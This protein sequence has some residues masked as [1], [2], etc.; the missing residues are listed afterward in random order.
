VAS[1]ASIDSFG[2]WK[3]LH[4]A[5]KRFYS[6]ILA[7]ACEEG[8]GVSLHVTNDT[9]NKVNGFMKWRLVDAITENV[10]MK[11]EREDVIEPLTA[12]EF[13]KLDFSKVLDTDEKRRNSYLEFK[14]TEE[15]LI[16]SS[17]IVLFV[18]AKHFNFKN[19]ELGINIKEESNRFVIGLTSKKLAKYIELDLKITDGVLSDNYFDMPGGETREIYL[20]KDSLTRRITLQELRTE[21]TV[22]SLYDSYEKA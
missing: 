20:N 15:D 16:L 4:Y 5:A 21:L 19:P 13:E 8:T 11:N 3:A 12:N 14:L 6:P 2:R 9:L 18:P 17:G 7:S 10:I 22:R 1:W